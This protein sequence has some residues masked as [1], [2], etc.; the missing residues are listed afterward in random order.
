MSVC[1]CLEG[2]N[3]PEGVSFVGCDSQTGGNTTPQRSPVHPNSGVLFQSTEIPVTN[4]I[5]WCSGTAPSDPVC[6]DS[7][8]PPNA[9]W[10][11]A[12]LGFVGTDGCLPKMLFRWF[13]GAMYVLHRRVRCR[14]L[15]DS[16][17]IC[18]SVCVCR[19]YS[20]SL[21]FPPTRCGFLR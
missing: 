12:A 9:L 17:G 5:P 1:E 19:W 18:T 11:S 4:D 7:M 16:Q 15:K 14:P 20:I 13:L 2:R 21:W 10:V 8:L 3:G 6:P